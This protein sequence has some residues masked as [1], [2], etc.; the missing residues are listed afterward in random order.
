[1]K[2]TKKFLVGLLACLS[3]FMS[4]LGLAACESLGGLLQSS[5]GGGQFSSESS[6]Q[7]TSSD[8]VCSH[9]WSAT[10]L[11]DEGYH[12]YACTFCK[13]VKEKSGHDWN[14]GVLNADLT[15]ETTVVKTYTCTVCNATKNESFNAT[16]VNESEWKA[17]FNESSLENVTIVQRTET[18]YGI[19]KSSAVSFFLTLRESETENDKEEK[20]YLNKSVYENGEFCGNGYLETLQSDGTYKREDMPEDMLKFMHNAKLMNIRGFCYFFFPSNIADTWAPDF[21]E[22]YSAFTYD[23]DSNAYIAGNVSSADSLY[24]EGKSYEKVKITFFNG[25]LARI[26]L[27]E[28]IIIEYIDY[29]T[30]VTQ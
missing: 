28:S 19:L 2:R 6:E 8:G 23:P 4:A 11:R 15:T 14:D 1:M 5:L 9:E 30:T 25:R 21:S 3:V 24:A 27:N 16:L 20:L 12:W 26:E 17:A 18:T 22:Y 13:E 7:S 10:W 29:G